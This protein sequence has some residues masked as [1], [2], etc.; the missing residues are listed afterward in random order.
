MLKFGNN[1]RQS[2]M[3]YMTNDVEPILVDTTEL[4]KNAIKYADYVTVRKLFVSSKSLLVIAVSVN[5]IKS[6]QSV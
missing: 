5:D 2:R 4:M 3:Q 1:K 6:V